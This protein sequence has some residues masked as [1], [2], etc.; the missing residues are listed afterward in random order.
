MFIIKIKKKVFEGIRICYIFLFSFI[1]KGCTIFNKQEM[2][3]QSRSFSTRLEGGVVNLDDF[4]QAL[5]AGNQIFDLGV[6]VVANEE[7]LF[8]GVV[9]NSQRLRAEEEYLQIT[10]SSRSSSRY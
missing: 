3:F 9:T 2:S 1:F 5:S 4:N 8:G 7:S 6:E 10:T